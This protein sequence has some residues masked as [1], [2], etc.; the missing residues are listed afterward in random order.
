MCLWLEWNNSSTYV[1]A[2]PV[3][4]L[5]GQVKFESNGEALD[6]PATVVDVVEASFYGGEYKQ[7]VHHPAE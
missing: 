4:L 2:A 3:E 6:T 1:L 5:S 7:G